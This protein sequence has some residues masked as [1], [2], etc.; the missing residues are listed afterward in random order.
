[1]LQC[2]NNMLIITIW[3]VL[4]EYRPPAT[5]HS[6]LSKFLREFSS[7]YSFSALFRTWMRPAAVRGPQQI[8]YQNV[9]LDPESSAIT[10]LRDSRV[11]R[12]FIL[13]KLRKISHRE[14]LGRPEKKYISTDIFNNE[15][16]WHT[17]TER[18]HLNFKTEV[19][20][21]YLQGFT[22]LIDSFYRF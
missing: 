7:Y 22:T 20:F 8:I 21:P 1:M 19:C 13:E 16:L 11:F 10:F 2:L 9:R 5:A 18:L 4:F 6:S 12:E 17:L 14:W 3:G 15:L